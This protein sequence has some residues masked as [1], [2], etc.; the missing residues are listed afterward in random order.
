MNKVFTRE[1]KTPLWK[2]YFQLRLLLVSSIVNFISYTPYFL[3]SSYDLYVIML[4][5]SINKEKFLNQNT[6][7]KMLKQ[8]GINFFPIFL[9]TPNRSLIHLFNP[10]TVAKDFSSIFTVLNHVKP[11]IIICYYL[12]DALP[13]VIFKK[14]FGYSLYV[15]VVGGDINLHKKLTF[16]IMRKFIYLGCNKIFAVSEDLKN[17]IKRVHNCEVVVVPLGTDP[18]FF[19]PLNSIKTLRRKWGIKQ[20]DIIILTVCNLNKNKGVD[21]IIEALDLLNIKQKKNIKLLI[22]GDGK[23]KF[24]LKKLSQKLGIQKNIFFLGFRNRLELLELYNLTDIFILASYSEGLPRV[25]IEA[26]A[27][28]CVSISTSVGDIPKIIVNGY[29]GFI[30]EP[31]NPVY[32][33]KQIGRVLSLTKDNIIFIKNNARKKVLDKLDQIKLSKKMKKIVLYNSSRKV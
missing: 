27:C 19:K 24:T 21:V 22:A 18:S 28:G 10:I 29:N 11:N 33:A 23:E 3:S 31:G 25:L 8:K 30:V 15:V 2:G 17:T 16:Q 13:L 9:K 32:L 7:I 26:M 1:K 20:K 12:L 14:F 6:E 4:I 5:P